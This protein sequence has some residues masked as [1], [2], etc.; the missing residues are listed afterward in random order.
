MSHYLTT[1]LPEAVPHR[2]FRIYVIEIAC[3]AM[4]SVIECA[5]IT[6]AVMRMGL[7]EQHSLRD[8]VVNI[9]NRG[10]KPHLKDSQD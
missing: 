10:N 9:Q 7:C 8:Q 1:R 6:A 4:A 5:L 3:P 2:F